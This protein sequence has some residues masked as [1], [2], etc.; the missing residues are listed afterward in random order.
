MEKKK[1]KFTLEYPMCSTIASLYAKLST[2][3]GL[4][5]WFADRVEKEN[6]IFTFF[7]QKEA[8]KADLLAEKENRYVRFRWLDEDENDDCYFE[9]CI[10]RQELTGDLT[11]SITD[12][13][14]GHEVEDAR[15]LWDLSIK[16][17]K[18]TLGAGQ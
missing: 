13:A 8:Q 12:F 11:L 16:E 3:E 18:R 9:F 5:S 1:R 6:G 7:W 2:E 14:G 17:L 15:D 10:D 4:G